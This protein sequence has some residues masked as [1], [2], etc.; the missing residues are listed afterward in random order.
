[1]TVV[2]INMIW[3]L[4]TGFWNPDPGAMSLVSPLNTVQ[5]TRMWD[6]F[7]WTL[8]RTLE[9][10]LFPV[11]GQVWPDLCC[12]RWKEMVIY[13]NIHLGTFLHFGHANMGVLK[14]PPPSLSRKSLFATSP[15]PSSSYKVFFCLTHLHCL[16]N[17][18]ECNLTFQHIFLFFFFLSKPNSSLIG[19]K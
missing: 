8:Y 9:C 19:R 15:L 4:Q 14:P 3:E 5:E 7:Y 12:Y 16:P 18:S 13:Y 2:T 10:G 11:S 1:M 17:F 6:V